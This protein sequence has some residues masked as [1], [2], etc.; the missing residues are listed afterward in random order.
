MYDVV[1]S[2][3]VRRLGEDHMAAAAHLVRVAAHY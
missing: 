2:H 1:D 3:I